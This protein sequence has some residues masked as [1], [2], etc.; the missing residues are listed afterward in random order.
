ML[1]SKTNLSVVNV[2]STDKHD[3][4]LTGVRVE[5]DGSTVASNG[6]MILAVGPARQDIA[7]PDVGTRSGPGKLG[8]VL[9]ANHIKEA[10]KNLP[11]ENRLTAMSNVA[12]TAPKDPAKVGLTCLRPDG[13]ERTIAM[14]PMSEGYP[15]WKQAVKKVHNQGMTVDP[16]TGRS[17]HH[18]NTANGQD[19][20]MVRA[21]VSRKDLIALLTA[22]DK[23][24]VDR[25]AEDVVFIEIGNGLKLRTY[26][27]ETEQHILG[28]LNAYN[29]R[30]QWLE[31]DEWE[32]EVLG[33]QTEETQPEIHIRSPIDQ[34]AVHLVDIVPPP[35]VTR[36]GTTR[37]RQ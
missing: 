20:G 28:T 36:A 6:R 15:D 35:P 17:L 13:S 29:T 32:C 11:K 23:A 21:A 9:E 5:P 4:G 31:Y 8:K 10:I 18:P 25:G 30:G 26:S 37:R 3:R 24:C 1:L 7:F 16:V 33:A 27:R 22:M 34:Q 14:R 19:T 12:M 2:V